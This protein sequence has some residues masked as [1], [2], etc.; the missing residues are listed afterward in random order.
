M[1]VVYMAAS[2]PLPIHE[3][4]PF[5]NAVTTSLNPVE[6]EYQHDRVTVVLNMDPYG[7]SVVESISVEGFHAPAGLILLHNRYCNRC[8]LESM[9]CQTPEHKNNSVEFNTKDILYYEF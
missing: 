6:L 4:T 3:K 9:I 5:A 7:P 2:T 1:S 8:Q